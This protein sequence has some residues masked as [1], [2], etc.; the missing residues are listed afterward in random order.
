MITSNA[1]YIACHNKK[2]IGSIDMLKPLK[3]DGIFV[4]NSNWKTLEEMEKNIPPKMKRQ[5]A[6]KNARFYTLNATEIAVKVGLGKRI[7]NIM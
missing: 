5:L 7:N 3:Q 6:E 4:L 1:N 2:Y